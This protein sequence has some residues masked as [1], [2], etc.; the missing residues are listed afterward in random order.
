MLNAIYNEQIKNDEN[1]KNLDEKINSLYDDSQKV[2]NINQEITSKSAEYYS[3]AESAAESINDSVLKKQI[4]EII[5]I[6]ADKN[7]LKEK[8]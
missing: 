8:S 5:K 6:S 2:K 7:Y 1:L 4:L 3:A